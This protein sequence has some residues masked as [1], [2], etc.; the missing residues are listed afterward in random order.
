MKTSKYT[1]ITS[2]GKQGYIIYN[3]LTD[4]IL[5]INQELLDL[6]RM[7]KEKIDALQY[8]HKD[9]FNALR[10]KGFII[11]DEIDE[12]AEL[13]K[14]WEQDENRTDTLSLI[15]NPTLDCN[16]HCWYC[17]EKHNKD[18]SMSVETLN[19]IFKLLH[20][21]CKK[22]EI[23]HI[24]LSFFGGEPLL[25]TSEIVLP[26]IEKL[27][28]YTRENNKSYSI[29]FTTNG[30][31]LT[32]DVI[33]QLQQFTKNISFQITLDGNK[34]LH[35]KTRFLAQNHQDSYDTIINNIKVAVLNQL[36]TCIRLNYTSKN[37]TSFIDILK[38]FEDIKGSNAYYFDFQRVWQDNNNPNITNEA[39]R[40]K[41]I[42]REHGFRVSMDSQ[43]SKTHC[44][45]DYKNNYVINYNGN[46]YKC[47]ARDFK[48][49]NRVGFLS[50]EGNI[51]M[52]DS[53]NK[54]I[55]NR[56][57]RNEC[58]DCI[59]FPI[60]HA[61]CIQHKLDS[62]DNNCCI[63]NFTDQ[64]KYNVIIERIKNILDP[65]ENI[66]EEKECC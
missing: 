3:T 37:I 42:F 19:A 26:I 21:Q 47:T 34:S 30:Y 61:G 49:G 59:I 62:K 25:F 14:N 39:K 7:N 57:N 65:S 54:C 45:A 4:K 24:N 28:A 5:G 40:V 10:E 38:D 1:Y 50:K 6:L 43:S 12:T 31:L 48:D 23:K 64:D 63:K 53:Y 22:E 11:D 33:T 18:M 29:S 2:N 41:S 66:T 9:F 58:K 8:I 35:N 60:C 16:F 32:K 17:Y 20:N 56:Y 36:Y 51:I 13:V 27:D 15:I 46:I 52:N 44:Y 55:A